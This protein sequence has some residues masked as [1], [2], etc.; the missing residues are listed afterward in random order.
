MNIDKLKKAAELFKN[1]EL[2]DGQYDDFLGVEMPDGEIGYIHIENDEENEV[3]NLEIYVGEEELESMMDACFYDDVFDG[4]KFAEYERKFLKTGLKLKFSVNDDDE[5]VPE[6]I[7]LESYHA[8]CEIAEEAEMERLYNAIM[9]AVAFSDE[10]DDIMDKFDD[11]AEEFDSFSEYFPMMAVK[12]EGYEYIGAKAIPEPETENPVPEH[13]NEEYV[14]KIRSFDAVGT[15]ECEIFMCPEAIPSEEGKPA[16]FEH[17]VLMCEKYS[18]QWVVSASSPDMKNNPEG[19]MDAVMSAIISREIRPADILT[20]DDR[21]N[22]MFTPLADAIDAHICIEENLP[23][24]DI[25]QDQIIN[26]SPDEQQKGVEEIEK[27]IKMV[28]DMS[29]EQRAALPDEV[30]KSVK[31]LVSSGALNEEYTNALKEKFGL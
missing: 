20:R 28:I 9:A 17:M 29:D 16:H 22:D 4:S 31:Y 23:E 10:F 1:C 27:F 21:T 14:E 12:D 25:L 24:L 26:T 8:E 5:A 19:V 15:W 30:V 6:F 7:K 13:I 2:W 3:R 18:G 11:E